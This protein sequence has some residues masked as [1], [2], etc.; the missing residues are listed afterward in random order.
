MNGKKWKFEII[1]GAILVATII[2]IFTI[3]FKPSSSISVLY[4]IPVLMTLFHPGRFISA[5]ATV[6]GTLFTLASLVYYKLSVQA[7]MDTT[8][9]AS[10]I[11]IAFYFIIKY[12]TQMLYIV[13]NILRIPNLVPWA[14]AWSCMLKRKMAVIYRL[15]SV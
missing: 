15:K 4:V 3:V 7:I 11:W 6:L 5:A 8:I 14:K 1:I 13:K 12:K 9:A 2:F 10:G